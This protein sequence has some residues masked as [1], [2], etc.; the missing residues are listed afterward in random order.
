MAF[1]CELLFVDW[2]SVFV[3]CRKRSD[4][5]RTTQRRLPRPRFTYVDEASIEGRQ[6][7]TLALKYVDI[8]PL[9]VGSLQYLGFPFIYNT[10]KEKENA[11]NRNLRL[12]SELRSVARIM[13]FFPLLLSSSF[14]SRLQQRPLLV[15]EK[16]LKM[17]LP[18]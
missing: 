10:K 13:F 12:Y 18:L 9:P 15:V 7:A 1:G 2:L 14:L 5:T 4:R 17:F 11:K 6:C 8:P 16:P 3:S